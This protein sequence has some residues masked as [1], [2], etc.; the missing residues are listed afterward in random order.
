MK[1]E[2]KSINGETIT[3]MSDRIAHWAIYR[4]LNLLGRL[5]KVNKSHPTPSTNVGERSKGQPNG[6]PLKLY[7]GIPYG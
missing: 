5:R 6:L 1:Q 3:T 2:K 7:C 4:Q